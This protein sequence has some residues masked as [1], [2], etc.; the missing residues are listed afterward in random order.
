MYSSDRVWGPVR[1]SENKWDVATRG[2]VVDFAKEGSRKSCR[3]FTRAGRTLEQTLMRNPETTAEKISPRLQIRET[4]ETYEDYCHVQTPSCSPPHH[5]TRPLFGGGGA[6][7]YQVR[8]VSTPDLYSFYSRDY[9]TCLARHEEVNLPI[10][11]LSTLC[12]GSHG[13]DEPH[14]PRHL[15]SPFVTFP[16]SV[17]EMNIQCRPN[18]GL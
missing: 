3:L 7:G 10:R 11:R 16:I 8:P 1:R 18:E 9:L 15:P 12:T 6:A 17:K 14:H 4:R 5:I 13:C 2:G